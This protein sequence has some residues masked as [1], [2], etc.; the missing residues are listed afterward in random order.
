M[1]DA[2]IQE[3]KTKPKADKSKLHDTQK[4]VDD[5]KDVLTEAAK[6][7][8]GPDATADGYTPSGAA[9]SPSVA[10]RASIVNV[11]A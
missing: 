8:E 3:A 10:P 5:A 6:A 9:S 1:Y 7:V 11:T 4:E 2:A